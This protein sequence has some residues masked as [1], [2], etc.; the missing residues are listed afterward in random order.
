MVSNDAN[1]VFFFVIKSFLPDFMIFLTF[2]LHYFMVGN[3]KI[4]TFAEVKNNKD[5]SKK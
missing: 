5:K 2:F 4:A 1:V 3:W